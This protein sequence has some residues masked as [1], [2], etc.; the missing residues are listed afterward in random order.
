MSYTFLR[1]C[2]VVLYYK[3]RGYYLDA[4]SNINLSQTFARQE[5]SRKTLHSKKRN[6]IIKSN[7][8]NK[9]NFS[10]TLLSTD[11][12][13]E[14]VVFELIGLDKEENFRFHVPETMQVVPET[15]DIYIISENDIFKLSNSVLESVDMPMSKNDA[16]SLGLNFS[17]S[18]K[19]R[20]YSLPNFEP[21]Y[22][23]GAPLG[24]G[25]IQA[26]INNTPFPSIIDS[27]INIQQSVEWFTDRTLHDIDQ[28][29]VPKRPYISDSSITFTLNTY[30]RNDFRTPDEP[31]YANIALEQ[32]GI[33]IDIRNALVNK[34]LTPEQV[35]Q[36]SYD[37]TITDKTIKTTVDYGGI[38]I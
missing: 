36:E 13:I 26:Q 23:Q 34:R 11:T 33:H 12:Y 15:C 5:Y 22:Y 10:F 7:K 18:S 2:K 38:L 3:E 28:V 1:E 17:G 4:L 35:F 29:S 30:L 37:I 6:K 16:L 24:A 32:A 8:K 9:Y 14:S 20:V 25:P 27:G 21:L 19:D 31:F